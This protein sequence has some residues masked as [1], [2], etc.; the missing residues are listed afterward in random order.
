MTPERYAAARHVL[1]E[2]RGLRAMMVDDALDGLGLKR[3]AV[4]TVSGF[5]SAVAI[6]RSS[7][8]VATVPDHH[9][10]GLRTDLESLEL[11]VSVDEFT[12]SLFWHPRL[13]VDPAHRWLR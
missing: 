10:A 11:P 6:A 4:A 2:R 7:D 9:T 5:G 1:V 3:R 8:M 13:D 12:I